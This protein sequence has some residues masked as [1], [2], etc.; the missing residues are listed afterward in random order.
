MVPVVV[1]GGDLVEES[2]GPELVHRPA[3]GARL[4]VKPRPGPGACIQKPHTPA[5][6]IA[7]CGNVVD[8]A[9][10][11]LKGDRERCVIVA[12]VAGVQVGVADLGGVGI[13]HHIG[14]LGAG[15]RWSRSCMK[16]MVVLTRPPVAVLS[17]PTVSDSSPTGL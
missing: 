11:H 9:V 15:I 16:E 7:G 14:D 1:G 5:A 13:A 6:V 12:D 3:P 10:G 2:A 8:V 4:V 17:A